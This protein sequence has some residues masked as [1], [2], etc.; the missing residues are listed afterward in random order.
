LIKKVSCR[1]LTSVAATTTASIQSTTVATAMAATDQVVVVSSSEQITEPIV[2]FHDDDNND[3]GTNSLVP[4]TTSVPP[5]TITTAIISPTTTNKEIPAEMAIRTETATTITET[6]A[7]TTA[8]ATATTTT[9]I[10]P[11]TQHHHPMTTTS[12]AKNHIIYLSPDADETLD[13]SSPPPS[14]VVIGM[15]VDRRVQPNRSKKRAAQ[16]IA[17]LSLSSTTTTTNPP[18]PTT[19][20]TANGRGEGGEHDTLLSNANVTP[21]PKASITSQCARLPLDALNVSDLGTDEALNIDTVLEIMQRWW[22]NYDAFSNSNGSCGSSSTVVCTDEDGGNGSGEPNDCTRCETMRVA[23]LR[24]CFVDAAARSMLTHRTR[25]PNRTI[26][27]GATSTP[28]K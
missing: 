16:S 18:H 22:N 9:E 15:L 21:P 6:T 5:T 8:T 26:H 25:H 24:N 1:R 7:T 14:I 20:T 28:Y 11:V 10:S 12:I 27:G 19:T 13:A 3:D 23:A 2:S 17:N 4:T